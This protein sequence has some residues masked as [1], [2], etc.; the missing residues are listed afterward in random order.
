MQSN[1]ASASRCTNDIA[2]CHDEDHQE[3]E[4]GISFTKGLRCMPGI[5]YTTDHITIINCKTGNS[6]P[7]HFIDEDLRVRLMTHGQ[8][9]Q[10]VGRDT[11]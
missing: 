2:N 5:I 1:K 8:K 3:E 11:M 7:S 10:H 4:S 6:T 9:Y